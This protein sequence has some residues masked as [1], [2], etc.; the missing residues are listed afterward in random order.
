MKNPDCNDMKLGIIVNP[1]LRRVGSG[2]VRIDP[3][4]PGRMSYKATKPGCIS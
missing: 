1:R 4:F 2:V 3:A